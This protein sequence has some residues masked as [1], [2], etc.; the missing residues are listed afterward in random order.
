MAGNLIAIGRVIGVHGLRGQLKVH[1]VT[2]NPERFEELRS[3]IL[4]LRDGKAVR[5][6]VEKIRT[7]ADEVFL[8]LEGV[9]DRTAAEAYRGAWV[10]VTREEI[11]ELDAD[12][13]Y[14]F[15]LE[16]MEVFNPDGTRLGV[17][18]RVEEFP[19]NGV[20]VV[21]SDTEEIWVPALKEIVREVDTANKRMT[22]V[23]PEGLPVY[24]KGGG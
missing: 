6:G 23:L 18:M 8:K 22:V 14:I 10:S 1:P 15:D 24:P 13:F 9:E 3:V 5:F 2:D 16:G 20:L 11:P 12:S 19:A 4:E 17:V 7:Q 21:E